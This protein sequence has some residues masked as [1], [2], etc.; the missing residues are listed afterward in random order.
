MVGVVQA[1]AWE[2]EVGRNAIINKSGAGLKVDVDRIK[3]IW[4][5]VTCVAIRGPYR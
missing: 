3:R 5:T 2:P 4:K 1:E